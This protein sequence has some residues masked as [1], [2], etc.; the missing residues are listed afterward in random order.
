MTMFSGF[1]LH[2]I[3]CLLKVMR[4]VMSYSKIMTFTNVFL[5]KDVIKNQCQIEYIG[6]RSFE[7]F[8]TNLIFSLF[9]FDKT[10]FRPGNNR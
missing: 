3:L 1:K 4:M 10:I 9:F 5:V 6:D 7:N 2:L 8:I